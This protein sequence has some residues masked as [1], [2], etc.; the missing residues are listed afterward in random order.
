MSRLNFDTE[1]KSASTTGMSFHTFMAH[2]RKREE[3][4]VRRGFLNNPRH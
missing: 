2:L 3:R 4:I 1:P